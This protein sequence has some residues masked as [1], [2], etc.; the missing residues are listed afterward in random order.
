M[1][2]PTP[3]RFRFH[4][5][6]LLL[7]VTACAIA[8]GILL[9]PTDPM[10]ARNGMTKLEVWWNCGYPDFKLSENAW[11]YFMQRPITRVLMQ[12]EDGVAVHAVCHVES[13]DRFDQS[14]GMLYPLPYEPELENATPREVG[15]NR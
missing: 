10:R 8:C 2:T 6:T 12:F 14:G 13:E 3:R 7:L 5:R 1:P 9:R 15:E 4:L 11:G